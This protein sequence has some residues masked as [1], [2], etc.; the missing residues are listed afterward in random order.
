MQVSM[1][2]LEAIERADQRERTLGTREF[3]GFG[4]DVWRTSELTWLDIRGKPKR[5]D[6]TIRVPVESTSIVE[7]KS[8][9]LYLM[10]FALLT[11]ASK[12]QVIAT[13]KAHLDE[14]LQASC[15]VTLNTG[16]PGFAFD[17]SFMEASHC[18][19]Y[20]PLGVSTFQPNQ[21]LLA[22]RRSASRASGR[23]HTDTFR[24]LCPISGQP[25]YATIVVSL[26][27]GWLSAESLLAYLVSFRTHPTFHESAVE[28]IFRDVMAV[29]EPSSCSVLGSF[30]RR[31][32]IDIVPFRSTTAGP[33]PNW[34]SPIA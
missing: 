31:G 18:L 17:P 22:P 23:Y 12:H 5:G 8:F 21:A 28:R 13:I 15:D 7:S 25:D 29:C 9:K 10:T 3:D 1:Q 30:A 20:I 33:A 16:T 4:A 11:F 34:R 26:Q 24:C 19:D 32:G 2:Q 27:S 14:L 6:L